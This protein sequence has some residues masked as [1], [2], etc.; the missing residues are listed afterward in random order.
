LKSETACANF[1]NLTG[2]PITQLTFTFIADTSIP[3]ANTVSCNSIDANLAQATC[4]VDQTF[5]T[6][7]A[8]ATTFFGG[9]PIPPSGP[10]NALSVFFLGEDGVALS[11]INNLTWT[12]SAP[13]P[14]SLSLL[15][16]GVGL[17]G[18]GLMLAKR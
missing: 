12:V 16:A 5:G 11:D 10:G 15:A 4:P 17:L 13:E 8:V 3:G 6:G 14:S 1:A 2:L 7:D 18:L 9:T